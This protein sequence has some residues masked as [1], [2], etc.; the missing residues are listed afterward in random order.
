VTPATPRRTLLVAATGGHLAQLH[1]LAP[2]LRTRP[3]DRTWVTFDTPQ[4]RSLLAKED[5]VVF[6]NFVAPRDLRNA[7]A[8]LTIAR[9]LIRSGRFDH[10]VSTG[11]A[12]ALSFL[13]VARA[14]GLRSTYVESAARSHGP[15]VTGRVLQHVPGVTLGTQ[16]RA[17]ADGQWRYV[18]SVLDAYQDVPRPDAA[19]TPRRILV[20][21]GTMPYAFTRLTERLRTILPD[22]ADVTWQL[23]VT[24]D[25]GTLPGTVHAMLPEAQLRALARAADVV[26]AHAG[27]GSAMT[28]LDAGRV[29]VLVPRHAAH[30][31]H[32]DDHQ[33][34]IASELAERNLALHREVDDLDSSDLTLASHRAVITITPAPLA[35]H[36][37]GATRDADQDVVIAAGD[38]PRFTPAHAERVG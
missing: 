24:P 30:G 1:A 11:S 16:H 10:V 38:T 4:S 22:D 31:E 2:R 12:V 6:V 7:A 37:T 18:G 26:V 9:R 25:P 20:T 32:V 21:L 36:G 15:S 29:P 28:A 17:W 13:P 5:E 27:T 34:Q 3:Q 35:L 19:R 33:H 14:Y 23:G 8:N